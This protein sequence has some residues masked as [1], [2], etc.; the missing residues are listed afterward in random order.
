MKKVLMLAPMSSVIERFCE[1]NFR[2]L[3]SI[4]AEVSVAANFDCCDHDRE[5][6]K[7]L[8]EAGIKTYQIPFVRSSLLS[9]LKNVKKIKKLL[10]E[11]G[12][13]LVHC[14]TETGG[15][16][17]RLSVRADKRT[18]YVFT[19]HGMSFYEGSSLKSRI[20]YKTIEKWICGKMDGNI[21]IN[22]GVVYRG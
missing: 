8:E 19:P 3:E 1:A 16:L 5:Y 2:A 4:G 20:V 13:D 12:F 22:K 9:N 15:I 6:R 7:S 14:H 11:G 18:R 21:A 17:T 10:R